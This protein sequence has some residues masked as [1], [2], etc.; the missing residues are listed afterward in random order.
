MDSLFNG[1]KKEF[2]IRNSRENNIF[3]L[4]NNF[5]WLIYCFK[6]F[7]RL[8][9]CFVRHLIKNTEK[10]STSMIDNLQHILL[11]IH[12]MND[13]FAGETKKNGDKPIE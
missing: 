4:I 7:S 13:N 6:E 8:A 11:F 1:E 5:Q 3:F 12:S 9:I 2:N 10:I